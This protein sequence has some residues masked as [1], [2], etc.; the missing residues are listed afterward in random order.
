MLYPVKDLRAFLTGSWRIA[1][2]IHDARQ[3][4]VGR[5]AGSANFASTS[6]GL[7]Y[8]ETGL[9]HFGSY[10]GEASRRYLFVFDQP[11][12]ANV[13][14]AD[15]SLFHLL[16]LSSGRDDIHH[17][18]GEDHYRGRYRV[19]DHDRFAASW[20]VAGPRKRYCMA[21]IYKQN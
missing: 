2:R 15:G 20:D 7:M 12:V 21:T 9:L 10:Q 4:M 14:H 18:C 17:Q 19:L 13:H 6:Q 1:R 5:L 11:G 16:N 3:G 8:D